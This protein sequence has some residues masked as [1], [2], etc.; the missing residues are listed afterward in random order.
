MCFK[1][2]NAM[3]C[4]ILV[5]IA[6][7]MTG[8]VSIVYDM[9]TDSIQLYGIVVGRRHCAVTQAEHAHNNKISYNRQVDL[10]DS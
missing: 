7:M 2:F 9:Y 6:K 1:L 3:S 10:K 8:K 4:I 5:I